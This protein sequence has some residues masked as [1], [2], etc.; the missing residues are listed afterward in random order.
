MHRRMVWLAVLAVS[1]LLSGWGWAEEMNSC[2]IC[3]TNGDI[4]KSLYQP[5]DMKNAEG[6]G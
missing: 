3:H 4:L 5:P 6:E 1:V 2:P